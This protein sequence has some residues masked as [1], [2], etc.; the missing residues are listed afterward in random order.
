MNLRI[1]VTA[2]VAVLGATALGWSAQSAATATD[3][4]LVRAEFAD[5]SPLLTGNEVKADG[6]PVGRVEALDAVGGHAVVTMLLQPS[7]LPVHRDARFTIRPASLLGERFVELD[8]GSVAAGSLAPGETVPLART[9]TNT[10]LDQVLNSLDDPTGAGLAALVGTLGG[11]LRGNGAN[12]AATL[13]ALTPALTDTR[14]FVDVLRDQNDVLNRMFDNVQ[15]VLGALAADRGAKLDHLVGSANGL[16]SVTTERQREL[17]S[18][19]TELPGLLNS[20]TAALDQVSG[21]ARATTPDLRSIR[22]LTERLP[23]VSGELRDFADALDPALASSRPMLKR[24]D[25]LL[26]E[27]RPVVAELRK[28]GPDL[29]GTTSGVRPLTDKLSHNVNNVLNFL[30]FWAQTA[31][32][33]DGL[34]NYFRGFVVANPQSVTGLLPPAV[35]D[36]VPLPGATERAGRALPLSAPGA[37][38]K[39]PA[40]PGLLGSGGSDGGLTG[41]NRAQERGFTGLLL[42]GGN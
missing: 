10:D 25:E 19:L 11:G 15:P 21:T 2:L 14:A 41:L 3:G 6:V 42:G 32:G 34:G 27:A 22:P 40:A 23:E 37:L 7:A 28:A 18:T 39:N 16:L 4:L 33:H 8:R 17:E 26:D 36:A 13:R 30:R 38:T 12:T 35:A 5:A 20:A 9:G 31:N 29:R 1:R 24:A